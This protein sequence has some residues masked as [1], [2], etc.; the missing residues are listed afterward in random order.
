MILQQPVDPVRVPALFIGRQRQD[1]VAIRLVSLAF[2][3][4]ERGHQDG[5]VDL[6]V[7]SAAAIEVAVLF[8]KLERIG[9]PILAPRFHDIQVADDQ[10]RLQARGPVPRYRATRLPLRS[11]GPRTLTSCG[12]NPAASSRL[13][14]A[15]AATVVLPTE[16][17]VLISMSC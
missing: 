4:N 10:D 17:V 15:S 1:D 13:A 2:E 12:A 5:V 6:H 7:L 3:A 11:F 16:S 14:I 9:G 8:D